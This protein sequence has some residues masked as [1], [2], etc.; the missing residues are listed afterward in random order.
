MKNDIKVK[1]EAP[2]RRKNPPSTA[3][4]RE[5]PSPHAFKAGGPSASPGGKAGKYRLLS[6]AL[7]AR[8]DARMPDDVAK[9]LHLPPGSSWAQGLA[10]SLMNA[11]IRGDINAVKLIGDL[12]GD[13]VRHHLE[14]GIGEGFD[15]DGEPISSTPLLE[16]HFTRPEYR[17]EA[18]RIEG[19]Q[20]ERISTDNQARR[21]LGPPPPQ[22]IEAHLDSPAGPVAENAQQ[23]EPVTVPK[24]PLGTMQSQPH[25]SRPAPPQPRPIIT[26]NSSGKHMG[27]IDAATRWPVSE[28]TRKAYEED[29]RRGRD[30]FAKP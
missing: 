1:V 18:E 11:G 10:A 20:R 5:N 12:S 29:V 28:E 2:Q 15:E 22:L 4:S 27:V 9:A 7:R 24:A 30:F 14:L 13:A 17:T 8:L 26:D 19:E 23:P 21:I 6:R 3:Y 16:V 25:T